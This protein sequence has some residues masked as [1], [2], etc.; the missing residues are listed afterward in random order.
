LGSI[1]VADT[2]SAL[3]DD[4]SVAIFNTVAFTLSL[5]TEVVMTRLALTR[6]QYYLR[7]NRL[8]RSGLVMRKN[9]K[10][11]LSS[12]GKVVYQCH[13]LI[14]HA[15]E[16]YWKLK[17]IDS[18]EASIPD[19]EVSAE[20]RKRIIDGLIERNDIK[21]VLLN[22]IIASGKNHKVLAVAAGPPQQHLK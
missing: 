15:I 19:D 16:S 8:V 6:K 14:G 21:N 11:F 4:K 5:D 10:Y 20:E 9:G 3:S 1:S 22:Q 13:M 7:M 18:I 2:L 12:L 17:A